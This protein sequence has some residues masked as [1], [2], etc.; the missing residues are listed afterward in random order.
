M[1]RATAPISE[2]DAQA[3]RDDGYLIVDG[4]FGSRDVAALQETVESFKRQGLLYDQS[5]TAKQNYQLHE[6]SECSSLLRALPWKASVKQCLTTLLGGDED[7]LEVMGDQMF[8]KPGLTGQGTSY[9]QDNAYF[10]RPEPERARG[11]GMWSKRTHAI[12]Q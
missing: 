9:H 5:V 3:F 4:L 10:R 8:L 1:G 11:T 2:A 6:I 7:P 12:R